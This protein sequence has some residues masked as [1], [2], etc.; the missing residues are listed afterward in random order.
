VSFWLATPKNCHQKMIKPENVL[1]TLR[2]HT[3]ELVLDKLDAATYMVAKARE[4][5]QPTL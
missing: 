1:V 3:Q 4:I 5:T 2:S